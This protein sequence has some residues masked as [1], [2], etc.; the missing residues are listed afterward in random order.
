M[1]NDLAE[2]IAIESVLGEPAP[3]APFGPGPR[4]ALDWFIA[5]AKSYGL[6]T[7]VL[8]GYCGYA[9]YGEGEKAIGILAHLD[10]VPADPKG[11][12]NPPFKM[13]NENGRVYG[14][15]V[16][17]DKGP[18]VAC[19]HVL[20]R[21]KE[22]NVRLTHR[23]RLIVG[24]NEENGSAC[25]KYYRAHGELPVVNLVPDADFPVI[26]S[27]KTI[28]QVEYAMTADKFF[29]DNVAELSAGVRPNVVPAACS[30]RL[31]EG[32]VT[33]RIRA[34]TGGDLSGLFTVPEVLSNILTLGFEPSAFGVIDEGG[35]T[36]TAEGV[37]GHAMEPEKGVN[38][39]AMVFSVLEPL[40]DGQSKTL[41]NI[42]EYI[43]SPLAP[44]KLGIYAE[45][46]TG[47][48]TLN[49]GTARLTENG[50]VFSL[51]FRC[52]VTADAAAIETKI[53]KICGG[54]FN[55]IQFTQNLYIEE[56]SPLVQTLLSVYTAVTGNE[57]YTVKTGGGTYARELPNSIAF[58]P[59]FPGEDTSIHNVD[60]NISVEH[61]FSLR[62]IYFQALIALDKIYGEV[63]HYGKG[64]E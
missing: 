38:A 19:L 20:K 33:Q 18:A 13:V 42:C 60:E 16:A 21:L 6:I 12:S 23:I 64:T 40:F 35:I 10:V 56:S 41:E 3:G 15:G 53:Q 25:M 54:T 28:K 27:E 57:G 22:E 5:K 43:L 30:V 29:T 48:L 8:D 37:A 51:D 58:G 39:I 17:D 50:P 61:L 63:N 31:R 44:E 14:R 24:T 4:A 45:D 55:T 11:W 1:L 59:T 2:L 9:E 34:R 46:V 52:P 47:A 49:V 7:G 26:N 32:A 36:I 62:E